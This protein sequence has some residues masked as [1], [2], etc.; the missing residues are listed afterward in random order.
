MWP[1]WR[2]L[3]SS[4]AQ[5]KYQFRI[6]KRAFGSKDASSTFYLL[7]MCVG[8]NAGNTCE[9]LIL[10]NSE[11][12]RLIDRG[13]IRDVDPIP[14]LLIGKEAAASCSTEPKMFVGR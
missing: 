6:I 5:N 7:V 8:E 9:H 14:Y 2:R 13:V 10:P 4:S 11:I 3:K 12:R 1:S